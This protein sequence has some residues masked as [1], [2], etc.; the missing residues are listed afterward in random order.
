M[1]VCVCVCVCVCWCVRVGIYS[2]GNYNII[3]I[4]GFIMFKMVNVHNFFISP[5]ID[6]LV[7]FVVSGDIYVYYLPD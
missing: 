5:S 6:W 7:V 1:F 4:R 3:P 2:P